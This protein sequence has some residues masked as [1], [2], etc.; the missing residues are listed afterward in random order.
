MS[1][2][3]LVAALAFAAVSLPAGAIAAGPAPS[4]KG[5]TMTMPMAKTSSHKKTCYD[6][7]WQ[8]QEWKDCEAKM[9]APGKK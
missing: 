5:M 6:A 9:A 3:T 2:R 4:A 7:A 8:S 1:F